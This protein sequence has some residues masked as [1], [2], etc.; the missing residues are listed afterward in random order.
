MMSGIIGSAINATG[1]MVNTAIT[2]GTT[3]KQNRLDREFNADQAQLSR[4]FNAAEAQKS[5][6]FSEY[7]SSTAYQRAIQDMEAAGLNPALAYSQGGASAG[8][9]A[10]ASSGAASFKSSGYENTARAAASAF[11]AFGNMLIQK[12]QAKEAYL[13]ASEISRSLKDFRL[14][15][16][17]RRLLQQFIGKW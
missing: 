13:N 16:E 7:M 11:E 9:G 12:G 6:D 14:P 5:R 8:G 3:A 4:D 2:A 17:D 10:S 1:Q 15:A